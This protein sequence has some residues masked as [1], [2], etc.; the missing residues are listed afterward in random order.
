VAALSPVLVSDA[1]RGRRVTTAPV[2]AIGAGLAVG[3]AEGLFF[4]LALADN[5]ALNRL[6][7][8]LVLGGPAAAGCGFAWLLRY[9]GVRAS[10]WRIA[11]AGVS[12]LVASAVGAFVALAFEGFGIARPDAERLLVFRV[13][14]V[15]ASTLA[16]GLCTFVTAR[17]LRL[18]GAH[19]VATLT[20]LATGASY[21][22]FLV[23][24]DQLPGWH[25]GGGARAMPRVAMLGNVLAGTV[26]GW[27]AFYLMTRDNFRRR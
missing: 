21:L 12:L 4:A 9:G 17:L 22:L 16:A 13:A 27:L 18:D 11:L 20:A 3:I 14:F 2:A 25:V 26:G 23:A 15:L 7:P 8:V 6:F 24:I 19:R 5:A 10:V 1:A